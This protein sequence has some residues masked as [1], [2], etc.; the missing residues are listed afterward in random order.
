MKSTLANTSTLKAF[1]RNEH[2]TSIVGGLILAHLAVGMVLACLSTSEHELRTI[3]FVALLFC[4]TS[5]VGAWLGFGSSHWLTR[6]II[7]TVTTCLLSIQLWWGV[8]EAN[9]ERLLPIGF[10][11][12][13]ATAIVAL[14]CW[15]GRWSGMAIQTPDHDHSAVQ[16][17]LQFGIRHLLAFTALVAS[18]AAAARYLESAIDSLGTYSTLAVIGSCQVSVGLASLWATLGFGHPLYRSMLAIAVSIIAGLV[19][20]YTVGRLETTMCIF[21]IGT[22]SLQTCMLVGSLM[23]LR[24]CGYRII[25]VA[26]L[27]QPA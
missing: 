3:P 1:R 20:A 27:P 26:N 17:G 8:S 2:T 23:A 22:T 9:L 19:S 7:S 15:I 21:W 25:K 24:Y 11:V 4:Q 18:L 12:V 14:T 5:L 16:E 6:A 13:L 10:L